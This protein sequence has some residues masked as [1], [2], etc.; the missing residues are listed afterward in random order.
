MKIYKLPTM[1]RGTFLSEMWRKTRTELGPVKKRAMRAHSRTVL[2]RCV[3]AVLVMVMCL[4]AGDLISSGIRQARGQSLFD[5]D[6][7][8]SQT[9]RRRQEE[10]RRSR[11]QRRADYC[12]KLEQRLVREWRRNNETRSELPEIRA[13]IK[14]AEAQFRKAKAR[15]ERKRCYE[16]TFFFGRSLR[17]TPQCVKLDREVREARRD[18]KALRQRRD[19]IQHSGPA[20]SRQD[21]LIAE[22]ARYGC[23]EDYERQYEARRPTFFSFFDDRG[24]PTAREPDSRRSSSELPF[25]T[26]RTMCV[27]QCDGYYFPVSFSTLPSQFAADETKCRERCAA[28]TELF[29]YRNPGEDVENMVSISGKPYGELENAWLYR[30]K[31]IKGCSC[32][33]ARYS[34]A[35]IA[36]SRAQLD[37]EA[38]ELSERTVINSDDTEPGKDKKRAASDQQEDDR[39]IIRDVPKPDSFD[40]RQR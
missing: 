6:Q 30:E 39:L 5:W 32:D 28:P 16:E 15:A 26:Y 35:E 33:A 8:P 13:K 9:E 25:A 11:S 38:A 4:V 21:E 20:R 34:K 12:H 2:S 37:G 31:F 40:P 14:K 1:T 22:L 29:V 27:R 24:A 18:V 3:P 36:K 23:G 17:R 7:R 10:R 19:R